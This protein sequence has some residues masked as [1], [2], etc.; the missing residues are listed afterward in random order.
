MKK[1]F[2]LLSISLLTLSCYRENDVFEAVVNI[3][4]NN[5]IEILSSDSNLNIPKL[6]LDLNAEQLRKEYSKPRNQWLKPHLDDG[7]EHIEIG[8]LE[9]VKNINYSKSKYDLGKMLFSE[10]KLSSSS[11]MSCLSCHNP[12]LGWSDNIKTP[13]G[14]DAQLLKRNSPSILNTVHNKTL[15]WDSRAKTL[16]EQAKMVLLNPQEMDSSEELVKKNIGDNPIYKNLFKQAFGSEEITLDKI[17]Q[18]IA[19]FERTITTKN[20][21]A[22]DQFVMGNTQ[23]LTDSQVRGL[24]IFRTVGRCMNCHNG[25]N[26]TDNKQHNIGLVLEGTK[27]ED[28][29]RYEITKKDSDYGLFKTPSLRNISKTAPYIHNGLIINLKGMIN[30]YS[31]GM[32]NA[33]NKSP[34]IRPIGLEMKDREDLISFLESLT[35]E[36]PQ[37]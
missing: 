16:E 6:K 19:T 30:M 21:S 37:L 35:E 8:N 24:H 33:R 17:S 2:I 29:G 22:F 26:F 28:T 31:N 32:P 10:T 11:T 18:A 15:F 12:R 14:L 23:A 3:E 9:T 27:Y 13:M 1:V 4:Q 34:H 25:S 20:K 36:I 5:D 7:V